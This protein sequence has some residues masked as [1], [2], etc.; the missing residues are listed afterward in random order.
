M[1]VVTGAAVLR[2]GGVLPRHSQRTFDLLG[3]AGPLFRVQVQFHALA[4][5]IGKG[6]AG[7]GGQLP[8]GLELLL[9]QLDLC[10]D[11][12]AIMISLSGE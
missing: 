5:Q 6:S 3:P 2:P 12:G 8:Q 4:D 10:T 7:G 1:A 9:G 11:H